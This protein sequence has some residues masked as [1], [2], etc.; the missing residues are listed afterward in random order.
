MVLLNQIKNLIELS[1][2]FILSINFIIILAIFILLYHILKY[3][4]IDRK[5][6]K[7]LKESREPKLVTIEDLKEIPLTNI[8][9]P[10]WKEGEIFEGC[11]LSIVKLTYPNLKIIV[12][13]GGSEET[14][15]IANSFKKYDN[16]TILYQTAGEGKIKAINDCLK[17]TSEGI[18]YFIDADMYLTD[19]I[20]F[21]MLYL[22]INENKEIV[23]SLYRPDES[24]ESIDIVKYAFFNRYEPFFKSIVTNRKDQISAHTCMKYTVIKSV[25]KLTEKRSFDDN[26]SISLDLYSK[27]YTVYRSSKMVQSFT[28]PK[29]VIEYM[30]QNLRW[31]ENAQFFN[32]KNNKFRFF[33]FFLIF[34]ISIYMFISPFLL[35][36]NIYF[37]LFGILILLSYYLKK[38]RKVIF[39]KLN[40]KK[41][42]IC[43]NFKFFIKL[44]YYIY[45][46]ALV[47]IIAFFEI[48]FYRKAYKKRKN[49]I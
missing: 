23:A 18:I 24:I 16:F 12:N 3:F 39:Y 31:V 15:N 32:L 8:I 26:S 38:I 25:G 42:S 6:I 46:D 14:I 4:V 37:F 27:G 20:F 29:K 22:I 13:A 33:K 7:A 43:L 19:E 36:L 11:L 2:N 41:D 10:A 45:V 47:V 17:H 28:Y 9:I 44:I 30:N 35:F 21:W 40:N 34:L 49:L 1:L 48:L 5:H